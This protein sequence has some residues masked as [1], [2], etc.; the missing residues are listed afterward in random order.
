MEENSSTWS[1][2]K[3]AFFEA[4]GLDTILSVCTIRQEVTCSLSGIFIELAQEVWN[5][6]GSHITSV[7]ERVVFQGQS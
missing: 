4:V 3:A 7:V 1:P 5:N 2:S 6:L